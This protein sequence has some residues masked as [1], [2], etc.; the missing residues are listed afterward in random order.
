MQLECQW[1]AEQS[2]IINPTVLNMSERARNFGQAAGT[3]CSWPNSTRYGGFRPEIDPGRSHSRFCPVTA[4][5]FATRDGTQSCNFCLPSRVQYRER[6]R[7]VLEESLKT[8]HFFHG[9]KLSL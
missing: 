9:R 4:V 1:S 8:S 5:R 3:G 6:N 2:A 7:A